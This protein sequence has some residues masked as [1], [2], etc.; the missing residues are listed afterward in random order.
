MAPMDGGAT[1]QLET[2]L[3]QQWDVGEEVKF[4]YAIIEF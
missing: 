1:S 2:L 3:T 4:A